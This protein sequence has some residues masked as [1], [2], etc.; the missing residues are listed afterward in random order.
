[1]EED[2]GGYL[3]LQGEDVSFVNGFT[4]EL[5]VDVRRI[6]GIDYRDRREIV[7]FFSRR[8]GLNATY[9]K[10]MRFFWIDRDDEKDYIGRFGPITSI[11]PENSKSSKGS[12]WSSRDG[13]ICSSKDFRKWNLNEDFYMTVTY[14]RWDDKE[15]DEKMQENSYDKFSYYYNGELLDYCYND[16]NNYEEGLKTWDGKENSFFVGVCPYQQ[17]TKN[18]YLNGDVYATRLYTVPLSSEEVKLNYDMTLKYR[19]SF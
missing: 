17:N 3:K 16:K 1:M 12:L 18:Y 13:V 7:G 11:E 14:T 8:S 5:Y 4:F 19:D 2:S 6:K 15:A 10:S 9:D